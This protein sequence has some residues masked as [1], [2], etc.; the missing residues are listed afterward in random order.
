[1]KI[2]ESLDEMINMTF[3]VFPEETCKWTDT[4]EY[5]TSCGC[6]VSFEIPYMT[7]GD[8]KYCPNCGKKIKYEEP[9]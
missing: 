9:K 6:V 3:A 5:N 2:P 1:M 7:D 4:H 8:I